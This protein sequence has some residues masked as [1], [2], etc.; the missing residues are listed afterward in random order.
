ML[1]TSSTFPRSA[2]RI[3]TSRERLEPFARSP[4][5]DDRLALAAMGPAS[6]SADILEPHLAPVVSASGRRP[7]A[8]AEAKPK[9]DRLDARTLREPLDAGFLPS[10]RRPDESLARA[11]QARRP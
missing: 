8:I 7:R 1:R 2:G 10:V 5:P 9:T 6:A 4:A 3:E 11:G